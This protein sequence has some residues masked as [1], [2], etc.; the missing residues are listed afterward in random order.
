MP[1][2]WK[3]TTQLTDLRSLVMHKMIQQR[4]RQQ[5]TKSSGDGKTIN[6]RHLGR[7]AVILVNQ[8]KLL[9]TMIYAVRSAVRG[10]PAVSLQPY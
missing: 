8:A 2:L 7:L 4:Q 1:L 3:L 10:V 6:G 5:H 9:L